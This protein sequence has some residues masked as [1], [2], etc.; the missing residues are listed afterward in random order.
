MLRA[1]PRC[2]QEQDR[3]SHRGQQARLPLVALTL[4]VGVTA[5]GSGSPSSA[6]TSTVTTVNAQVAQYDFCTNVVADWVGN[7]ATAFVNNDTTQA[8]QVAYALGEQNPIAQWIIHTGASEA[9]SAAQVGEQQAAATAGSNI[10]IQ[11]S[12]WVAHGVDTAIPK[13]AN[14]TYAY[15]TQ[16]VASYNPNSPGVQVP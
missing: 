3:G 11:C 14:S 12:Y 13:P 7:E 2:L 4:L 16:P 1:S 9:Q 6:P 5:C 15:G 8:A 10:E